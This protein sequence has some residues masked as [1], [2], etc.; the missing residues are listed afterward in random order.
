M[1]FFNLRSVFSETRQSSSKS[2]HKNGFTLI[3][4]LVV[5]AI[6]AVLVA[7]LLPAVQQAREAARMAQCKNNLRQIVLA[8]HMYADSN[9][10]YWPPASA[11][12]GDYVNGNKERWHGK[13]VTSNGT[14]K[15]R[16]HLGPL[17]PYLEQNAAIKKCPT[18]GNFGEHG[19]VANAFEGGA[20]GY[21]YNQT[22]LGGTPWKNTSDLLYQVPTRM[23]EI[24]SLARTVAFADAALAQGFPDLHIIEYSFIEPPF[25]IDSWGSPGSTPPVPPTFEE[26]TFRPDPSIH[27]RHTGTV[28]NIG[29]A[30]G[31]VTSA[32][33]SGTG[34]SAY[35]GDPKKFQIGWFGPM[36]SN[37]LFSHKDKLNSEMGGVQ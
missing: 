19:T 14:T 31:R 24:G 1:S 36:D 29:W 16:P 27:F 4:L 13:R 9:S 22:Y 28:A 32:V 23:R 18:F 30:D 15:F 7:L 11:D 20:G 3:E 37:I 8:C 34:T 12:G 33:M 17:A 6:I 2:S 21:G 26:T 5:I 35:G 10:G 25:F